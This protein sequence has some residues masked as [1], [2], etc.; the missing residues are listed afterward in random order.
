DGQLYLAG[1]N[2]LGSSAKGVSAIQ[3]LRYTGL[4][5]LIPKDFSVGNQG[6]IFSFNTKIDSAMAIDPSNYRVKRWNYKRTEMYGSGHFRMDGDPGEE[7]LPVLGAY[8]SKDQRKILLLIPDLK[9]VDQMEILY[10]LKTKN[11]KKYKDGIWFS[12]NHINDFNF[13]SEGFN[14]VDLNLL[15]ID[16]QKIQE[17]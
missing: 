3:R 16:E 6:V 1:F 5:T 4:E 10:E 7:I 13:R 2:L 8:L 17:L 11:E 12:I 14:N 15:Q 9:K